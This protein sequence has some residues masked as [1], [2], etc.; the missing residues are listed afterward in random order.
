MTTRIAIAEDDPVTRKNYRQ[1][2]SFFDDI[3]I[4]AAAEDGY[5]LLE[6]LERLSG[7]VRPHIVLMDIELPGLS[8]IDVTALVKEAYPDMEIM[9]LTVFQ[10]D[11]RIFQSVQAGASGY[12]LKDCSTDEL[13]RA[14]RDLREGGVP[15]SRSIARKMLHFMREDGF[16]IPRKQDSPASER[17]ELTQRE[18]EILERIV[19]DEKEFTIAQNLEISQATVHTHIKN[20][21][22]KLRVHSRGAVVKAAL[23]H[24]LVRPHP[25]N[26]GNPT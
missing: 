23:Q 1:R 18:V 3:A 26:P 14:I 19:R 17:F 9:M 16:E 22:K 21:Y 8:G 6:K 4:V 15:L 12:L 10:D 5:E 20:I 7:D 25:L 11:E 13:V 24:R 2:F